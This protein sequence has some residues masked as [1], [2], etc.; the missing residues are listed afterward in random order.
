VWVFVLSA[1]MSVCHVWAVSKQD[2]GFP[3]TKVTKP[4]VVVSL[5]VDARSGAQVCWK[6]SQ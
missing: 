3:G 1:C 2:I 5:H 6:D 4:R